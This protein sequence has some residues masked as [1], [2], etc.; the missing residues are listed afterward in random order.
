MFHSNIAEVVNWRC[1][2][3]NVNVFILCAC[4]VWYGATREGAIR[5]PMQYSALCRPWS[6]Q[7][8]VEFL[9][10]QARVRGRLCTWRCDCCVWSRPGAAY[11]IPSFQHY[12]VF[13][14]HCS[15]SGAAF[16]G[17][18]LGRDRLDGVLTCGVGVER[19]D[20]CNV[21]AN[22]LP[23]VRHGDSCRRRRQSHRWIT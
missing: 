12:G 1:D 10:S 20:E 22:V 18:H 8:N 9:S 6:L 2:V 17:D 5:A 7:G 16:T 21:N 23:S 3:G 11:V 15:G 4:G 14:W 19:A 13:H